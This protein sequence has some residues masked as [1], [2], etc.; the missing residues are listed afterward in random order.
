MSDVDAKK[1][2]DLTALHFAALKGH[3]EV[4]KFLFENGAEINAKDEN[5][6]TP[7]H[8]AA[9]NIQGSGT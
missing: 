8:F 4:V 5:N 6:H 3:T 2:G 7:F 1:K 9:K